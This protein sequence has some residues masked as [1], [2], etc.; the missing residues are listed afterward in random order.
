[1]IKEIPYLTADD[2][3]KVPFVLEGISSRFIREYMVVPLEL[4]NNVLKVV[5]ANPEDRETIDALRVATR[6]I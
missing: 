5:M 3:P 2:L 1:M 4:K 6:P